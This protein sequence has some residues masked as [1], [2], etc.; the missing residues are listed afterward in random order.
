MELIVVAVRDS[1]VDA[2]MRPFF[3]PTTGVAVRSFSDEVLRAESE[4]HK[5]PADYELFELG[6]FDEET[7][8]F[9]NVSAPRSLIRAVDIALDKEKRG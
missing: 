3:V 9:Q 6:R 1:A 7:G 2:F 4:M 8:K 5:H